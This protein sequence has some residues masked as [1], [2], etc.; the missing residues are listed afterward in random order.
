VLGAGRAQISWLPFVN[1]IVF[2]LSI[3]W[4]RFW[5]TTLLGINARFAIKL[6]RN[7][8]RT[9]LMVWIDVAIRA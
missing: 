8:A 6:G 4:L 5:D 9:Y 2:V 1:T 7:H 3:E